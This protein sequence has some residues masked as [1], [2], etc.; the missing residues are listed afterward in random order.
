[1]HLLRQAAMF[2]PVNVHINVNVSRWEYRARLS[3]S[4]ARIIEKQI[5]EVQKYEINNDDK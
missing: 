3:Q 4:T 5:T 2:V 1:M